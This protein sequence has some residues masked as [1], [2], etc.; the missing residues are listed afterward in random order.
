MKG[1]KPTKSE[2]D[3]MDKVSELGCIVCRM[4]GRYRVPAEIHHVEGKTKP[5]AHFK[6][7]PLCFVHHR[8]GRYDEPVSRHP[9]KKRF[10]DAYGSEESL[11]QKVKT[12]IEH[13]E[14][15]DEYLF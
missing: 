2:A 15:S 9:Y 1:R 5:D 4:Q 13:Q 6:I 14:N 8:A 10:I 12:L 3:Y 11:M 7:I